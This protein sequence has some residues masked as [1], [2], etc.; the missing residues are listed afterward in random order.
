MV[1]IVCL[2]HRAGCIVCY[3]IVL[4]CIVLCYCIVDE[5]P[6]FRRNY[7]ELQ[8]PGLLRS[9]TVLPVKKFPSLH[10]T[11]LPPEANILRS[12]TVLG[13]YNRPHTLGPC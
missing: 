10:A 4:Y 8:D 1:L 12:H 9:Q 3:G 2:L 13:S 7:S 11:N 5:L 6:T